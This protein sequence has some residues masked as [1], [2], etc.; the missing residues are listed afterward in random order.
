MAAEAEMKRMKI[1]E[2]H[3]YAKKVITAP[4]AEKLFKAKILGAK[5]WPKLQELIIRK[6]GGK[7]VVPVTDK[8]P[9]LTHVAD[10]F[11]VVEGEV[12]SKVVEETEEV[13]SFTDQD[14][15]EIERKQNPKAAEVNIDDFM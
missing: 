10:Q 7:T 6:P 3:M 13:S 1:R 15:D 2:E 12:A 11:E 5:Q 8:R 4:Q 9:A 14:W